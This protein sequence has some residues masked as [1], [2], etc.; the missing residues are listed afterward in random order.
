MLGGSAARGQGAVRAGFSGCYWRKKW[1]FPEVL[2]S[3]E[4]KRGGVPRT[5][6]LRMYHTKK[7]IKGRHVERLPK[8]TKTVK[9]KTTAIKT[10]L[11]HPG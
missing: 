5:K 4:G 9:T 8:F 7:K 10:V 1:K 11:S 6:S 2:K 3:R